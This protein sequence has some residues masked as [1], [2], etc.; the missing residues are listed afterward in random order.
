ML[1][2]RL[3]EFTKQ[4]HLSLEKRLITK[5]KNIQNKADYT[6][7]LVLMYGYYYALE[8]KINKFINVH[9]LPDHTKRR[10]SELIL[11]DIREL[12]AIK[13]STLSVCSDIPSI[14]SK[15]DA[16]AA[17]YVLEGSTL[18]GLFIAD[19]ISGR[20]K[21]DKTLSFFRGYGKEDTL[22]MWN[23]FK[24]F[25]NKLTLNEEQEQKLLVT[26][27]AVFQKFENWI[28]INE[29]QN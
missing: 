29:Q 16:F 13:E 26:A 15:E 24:D 25:L 21:S 18:G 7:L 12:A 4:A 17:M 3:K 23:S 5:I 14:D 11:Q 20:L 1:S 2:D 19:M 28:L 6:R 10:K 9:I 8:V 22:P 27:D